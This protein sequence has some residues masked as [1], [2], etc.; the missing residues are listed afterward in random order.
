[1]I[2]D[3]QKQFITDKI[4]IEKYF[5]LLEIKPDVEE[6]ENPIKSNLIGDIEFKNVQF[7]YPLRKKDHKDEVVDELQP[8][9]VLKGLTFII[10]QGEKVAFV[11][12]SGSG[13]F[14]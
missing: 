10:K 14:I 1:M 12:E 6:I 8:E 9:M 7:S 13:K 4:N 11:G 5:E 2:T 3:M